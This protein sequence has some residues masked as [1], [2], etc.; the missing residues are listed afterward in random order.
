M[1]SLTRFG[2]SLD[3]ELL[4]KFDQLVENKGYQNR[5]EALRDLIRDVLVRREWETEDGEVVGTITMIYDHH[6]HEVSSNLTHAQHDHHEQIISTMHVHLDHANCLEVL[7]VRGSGKAVQK[8][9]DY[10]ISLKGVKHGKLV[11]TT[12]GR[13]L[14]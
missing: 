5:S 1:S 11:M 14:R 4:Q 12:T 7:V 8:L 6:L 2:M 13:Q 3:A 10:L 9:A